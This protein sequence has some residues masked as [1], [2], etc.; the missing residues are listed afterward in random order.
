MKLILLALLTIGPIY[1]QTTLHH[2]H[3]EKSSTT[4][5]V[6][7]E[8]EKKIVLEVLQKNDDLFNAF[9]KKDS[10]AIVKTADSLRNLI[11]KSEIKVLAETKKKADSLSKINSSATH[12]ENLASYEAFNNSLLNV[13]KTYDVGSKFNIFHC[14]MVKKS[15]IQNVDTNKDIRNVYAMEMLECGTQ[16]THF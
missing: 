7:I 4:R 2:G 1:A 12:E 8:N 16:E 9:L 15:W 3:E 10:K 14:P 11:S 6:L 5:K 13:V